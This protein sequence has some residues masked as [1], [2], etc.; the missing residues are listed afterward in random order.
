MRTTHKPVSI[1]SP[2]H[3]T[4]MHLSYSELLSRNDLVNFIVS[5]F[6]STR[7]FT[8]KPLVSSLYLLKVLPGKLVCSIHHFIEMLKQDGIN[9]FHTFP[10]VTTIRE[11]IFTVPI[12]A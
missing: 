3:S 12:V 10:L 5:N 8:T 7:K 2:S 1:P 6:T 4:V 11:D 9:N